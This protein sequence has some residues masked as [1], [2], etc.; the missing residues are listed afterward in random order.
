[1]PGKCKSFVDIVCF[2][3]QINVVTKCVRGQSTVDRSKNF[4]SRLFGFC[5]FDPS[6][7][8]VSS[9][10]VTKHHGILTY[11]IHFAADKSIGFITQ[12]VYLY[13]DR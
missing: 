6:P 4:V 5:G 13:A 7:Y 9:F 10:E 12:T 8:P 1:M 11:C 3:F 2:A